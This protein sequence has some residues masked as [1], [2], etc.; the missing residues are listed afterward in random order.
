M[1]S[2]SGNGGS[3]LSSEEE[4]DTGMLNFLA[5]GEGNMEWVSV[6]GIVNAIVERFQLGI[7]RYEKERDTLNSTHSSTVLQNSRPGCKMKGWM[8]GFYNE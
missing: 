6:M 5:M 7:C 4:D 8:H 2:G 3:F 1:I